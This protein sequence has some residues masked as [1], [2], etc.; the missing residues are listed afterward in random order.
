MSIK[1][2]SNGTADCGCESELSVNETNPVNEVA[3]NDGVDNIV[4][5]EDDVFN[6]ENDTIK[7]EAGKDMMSSIVQDEDESYNKKCN[8][9]YIQS[10]ENGN[11]EITQSIESQSQENR[12]KDCQ[13][14]STLQHSEKQRKR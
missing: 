3:D 1:E 6:I 5:I 8:I 9:E 2:K 14:V 4:T 13:I 11:K 12:S 10:E 7:C